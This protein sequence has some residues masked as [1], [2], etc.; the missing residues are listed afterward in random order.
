MK[1][2]MTLYVSESTLQQSDSGVFPESSRL[3][4]SWAMD[5]TG[6]SEWTDIDLLFATLSDGRVETDLGGLANITL[7]FEIGCT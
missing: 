4:S 5:T 7:A 3:H 2:G 6:W 1:S